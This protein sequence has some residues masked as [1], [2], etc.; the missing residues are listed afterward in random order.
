MA[1]MRKGQRLVCQPCG[2]EVV[3][4]ACGISGRTLWCCDKPMTAKTKKT[5]KKK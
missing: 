3:V 2:R 1:K 5:T 4:D